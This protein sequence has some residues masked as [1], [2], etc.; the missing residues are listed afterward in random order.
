MIT[1]KNT[2]EIAGSKRAGDEQTSRTKK[3]REDVFD[4]DSTV[5]PLDDLEFGAIETQSIPQESQQNPPSPEPVNSADQAAKPNPWAKLYDLPRK[6]YAFLALV[7]VGLIIGFYLLALQ[8]YTVET[9]LAFIVGDAKALDKEGWSPV[10]ELS[11]LQNPGTVS[12]LSRRYY[13]GF[14][15]INL[16]NKNDKKPI[17][18]IPLTTTFVDPLTIKKNHFQKSVEFE[19][20][21]SKSMSF[22]PDFYG[23]QNRVA[24]KIT[25][26]DPALLKGVLK[27]YIGSYV[28]LR[29]A[30]NS[31][32]KEKLET[33]T[34]PNTEKS[35]KEKSVQKIDERINTLDTLQYEYKLALKLMDLGNGSF[36]ALSLDAKNPVSAT[37]TRLQDK[38]MQLEVDRAS[39]ETRF[40]PQSREIKSIDFQI[41]GVKGLMR[42]YLVE[43][44][45]YLSKDRDFLVAQ[46]NEL[47]NKTPDTKITEEPKNLG[48]P[49]DKVLAGAN[50][51]LLSDGL[52]LVAENPFV[53]V[54]PLLAKLSE[55]KDAF[56]SSLFASPSN[57]T[58]PS[59]YFDQRGQYPSPGRPYETSSFR[60]GPMNDYGPGQS[61]ELYRH[62]M[63]SFVRR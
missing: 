45:D 4:R 2:L 15:P 10:R 18:S 17:D 43:Q 28:D 33:S 55:A 24:V 54:K 38:V 36:T 47:E 19:S 61:M 62:D 46:K 5:S 48:Q 32:S 40:T 30:I 29:R 56:V 52:S 57:R 7:I 58:G 13:N 22:E 31:R 39:L 23:G 53:A 20:W 51:Y 12:L 41:Q 16:F 44:I 21:I 42:Q 1:G 9:R 11:I 34:E 49:S 8:T 25:G 37:L 6:Y 27:D 26:S 63:N 3:F 59:P 50:W 60:G 14:D 35:A